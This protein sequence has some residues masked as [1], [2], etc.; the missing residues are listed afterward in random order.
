M[1]HQLS[2]RN[3]R[4][5][6]AKWIKHDEGLSLKPYLC[7]SG[8]HTIGYGHNLD[9]HPIGIPLELL[10]KYGI[11]E[12]GAIVLLNEDMECC[13]SKL[14]NL[15][16]FNTLSL[17]R[18]VVLIN[19]CFNLGYPRLTLFKKMFQA[20]SKGNYAQASFEMLDSRWATQVPKRTRRLANTMLTNEL[21]AI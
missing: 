12:E 7:T 20:L 21:S 3:M 14:G 18:K 13:I 2:G 8:F 10:Q 16:V 17:P 6:A 4:I 11:S 1:D 15:S 19:M 5:E 9:Y